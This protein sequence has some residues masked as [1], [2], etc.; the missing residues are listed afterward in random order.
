MNFSKKKKDKT[1]EE[2]IENFLDFMKR[3]R[4]TIED[5]YG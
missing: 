5:N 3:R 4:K 2:E 1:K